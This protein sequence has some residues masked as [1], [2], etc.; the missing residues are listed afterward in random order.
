[1]LS[2]LFLLLGQSIQS[3]LSDLSD[4]SDQSDGRLHTKRL[5]RGL[6]QTVPLQFYART[7]YSFGRQEAEN[8]G[9][10]GA[11]K[12]PNDPWWEAEVDGH[13]VGAP[14][15]PGHVSLPDAVRAAWG[16]R[17]WGERL[18]QKQWVEHADQLVDLAL[19][20]PMGRG[21]RPWECS[22]NPL[23]WPETAGF[24]ARLAFWYVRW[25]EQWP[26]DE[27]KSE[28]DRRV[29]ETLSHCEQEQ[30]RLDAQ[31][32]WFINDRGGHWLDPEQA[33]FVGRFVRFPHADE[34][35]RKR[36]MKL[37]D[38]QK[39]GFGEGWS[40]NYPYGAGLARLE[41]VRNGRLKISELTG[42]G[43]VNL[44]WLKDSD[45]TPSFDEFGRLQGIGNDSAIAEEALYLMRVGSLSHKRGSFERG[46][47]ALRS[48]LNLLQE[49]SL[50]ANG[51]VLPD[52]IPIGSMATHFDG[53]E[54]RVSGRHSFEKYEG[55]MIASF[56]EA[57]DEFG[58]FYID[59][60]GWA[61]GIDGCYP[62]KNN[63][64]VSNLSSNPVP[65]RGEHKVE[66]VQP[67]KPRR[68][69]E[70]NI[71]ASICRIVAEQTADGPV[72]IAIPGVAP[73]TKSRPTASGQFS[74]AGMK[75]KGVAKIGPRGLVCPWP[76]D[77]VAGTFSFKG[78]IGDTEV[79]F[80]P[81]VVNRP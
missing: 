50:R 38:R 25:L 3:D 39:G 46:V 40:M 32:R 17:W 49:P 22:I 78:K 61:V 36:A 43:T 28:I 72:L 64:P 76:K 5:E 7:V 68:T 71:L 34:S 80:G 62:G 15:K 75:W 48:D 2:C 69:V 59:P 67:G 29:D 26:N 47:A 55:R 63:E 79:S 4:L 60:T 11:K 77:V 20:A 53:Q 12:D 6:P 31:P 57:L 41:D 21:G 10:E 70:V 16:M 18:K 54:Y 73:L 81:V 37:L 42:E 66:I 8:E 33:R 13:D 24:D 19:A 30:G 9:P 74:L 14:R 45:D 44:Q 1:M 65:Y 27:R 56:A 58:G 51:I 23:K 52:S 35:L